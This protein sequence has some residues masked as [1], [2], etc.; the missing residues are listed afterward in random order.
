MAAKNA[1]AAYKAEVDPD[2]HIPVFPTNEALR[3]ILYKELFVGPCKCCGNYKHGI[4]SNDIDFGGQERISLACPVIE[5]QNWEHVLQYGLCRMTF[6]PNAHLFA[7]HYPVATAEALKS[8]RRHG[9]GKQMNYMPLVDFE[10][11]V[12]RWVEEERREKDAQ[13]HLGSIKKPRY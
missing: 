9:Y 3:Q 4:L 10:N 6:L 12:H 8:F 11:D 1:K 5:G 2:A 7:K 13:G